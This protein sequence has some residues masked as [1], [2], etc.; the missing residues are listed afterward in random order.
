M[1]TKGEAISESLNLAERS[2]IV[3]LG[4]N[5]VNGYPYIKGMIKRENEGLRTVWLST[6]TSSMRVAQIAKNPKTCLYFVD[7][8]RWE[9]LMLV[10]TTEVLQ[11]PESKK[12]LWEDGDHRYYPKGVNDPDYTVLRFTSEWGNYYHKL[13]NLAFTIEEVEGRDSSI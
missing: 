8:D 3:M 2:E 4:S 1:M 5:G 6:N 11:D 13:S 9:G 7:F 10:G 12:R